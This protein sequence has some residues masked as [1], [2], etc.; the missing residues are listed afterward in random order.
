METYEFQSKQHVRELLCPA[1]TIRKSCLFALGKN[2]IACHAVQHGEA[3]ARISGKDDRDEPRLSQHPL[4]FVDL[5]PDDDLALRILRAYRAN[6]NTHWVI[7]GEFKK[8]KA[9]RVWDEMNKHQEQ[10]AKILDAAIDQE[11]KR[12]GGG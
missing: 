4:E 2:D 10:R 7:S 8:H 6:C 3:Y 11:R 12:V 1:C 9:R 5:T